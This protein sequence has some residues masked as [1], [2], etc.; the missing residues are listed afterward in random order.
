M[1]GGS[2][3]PKRSCDPARHDDPACGTR[4]LKSSRPDL[5]RSQPVAHRLPARRLQAKRLSSRL[6]GRQ[7]I[8][9]GRA[10]GD[11]PH[12]AWPFCRSRPNCDPTCTR[13]GCRLRA[14]AR[15]PENRTAGARAVPSSA[16]G[17]RPGVVTDRETTPTS[18]RP[19]ATSAQH[20]RSA[21]HHSS[22]SMSAQPWPWKCGAYGPG[23]EPDRLPRRAP[24]DHQV[25]VLAKVARNQAHS[26]PI[27]LRATW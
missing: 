10:S 2:E 14:Y 6:H 20:S 18:R 22:G 25:M 27:V 1:R 21:C 23:R 3:R 17:V 8:G 4:R 19:S 5:I 7:L 11:P 15:P 13:V 24:R 9:A 26:S 12:T 16:M